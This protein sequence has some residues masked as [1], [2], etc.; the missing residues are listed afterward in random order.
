MS[1]SIWKPKITDKNLFL[2]ITNQS[3]GIIFKKSYVLNKNALIT[4]KDLNRYITLH[5][6][7]NTITI[8]INRPEMV[9]FKF[10]E[11]VFTKKKASKPRKQVKVTKKKK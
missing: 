4:K 10:G 5:S 2:E 9:G 3:R 6:G 1:R 11:F 8:K 7:N